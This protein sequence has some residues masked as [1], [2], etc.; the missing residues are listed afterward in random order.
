ML[1]ARIYVGSDMVGIMD[2]R[3]ENE[4]RGYAQKISNAYPDELTTLRTSSSNRKVVIKPTP[5]VVRVSFELKR[6]PHKEIKR[7]PR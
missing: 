7:R 1:S 4:A 6:T 5:G 2:C 3:G